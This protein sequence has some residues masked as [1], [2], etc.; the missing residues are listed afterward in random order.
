MIPSEI[1]IA[2]KTFPLR[3]NS[4]E[5]AW[6]QDLEAEIN[7]KIDDFRHQY[8]HLDKVDSIIMTLLTYAF[9]SRKILSN[10]VLPANED[11]NPALD[12]ILELLSRS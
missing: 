3:L 10:P 9:D 2:G 4:E 8:A 1:T 12:D 5:L 7:R 11:I 6:V